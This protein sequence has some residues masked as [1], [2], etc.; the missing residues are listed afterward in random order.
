MYRTLHHDHVTNEKFFIE[1]KVTF[2][3]IFE[4]EVS[5]ARPGFRIFYHSV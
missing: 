4:I 3:W 2:E 5:E 1:G